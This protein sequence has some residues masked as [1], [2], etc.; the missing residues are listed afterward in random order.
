LGFLEDLQFRQEEIDDRLLLAIEPAGQNQYEQ[1]PGLEY[2][3][4]GALRS[5][6]GDGDRIEI[7]RWLSIGSE[8]LATRDVSGGRGG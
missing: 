2:D 7:Q 8:G 5:A 4:H 3:V 1:L 6:L